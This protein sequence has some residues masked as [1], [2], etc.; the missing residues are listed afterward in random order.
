MYNQKQIKNASEFASE[1][2]AN[3]HR[4]IMCISLF[5]VMEVNEQIFLFEDE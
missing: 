5:F 4:R 2:D 3:Y 1:M